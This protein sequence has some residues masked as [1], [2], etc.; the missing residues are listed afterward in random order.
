MNSLVYTLGALG[1]AQTWGRAAL[2]G[3]MRHLVPVLLGRADYVLPGTSTPLRQ[4]FTGVYWPVDFV[5]R[6][7][8][9][10]FYEAV[11][12]SHPATSAIGIYFL[13]QYLGCL[14]VMYTDSLRGSRPSVLRSVRFPPPP[15][16]MYG[17]AR[18]ADMSCV[19]RRRATMWSLLFQLT[20]IGCT[21]WVWALSFLSTSATVV[22]G[23]GGGGGEPRDRGKAGLLGASSV[24]DS[25]SIYLLPPAFLLGYVVPAVAMALP[26]P[27]MVSE[28][29]QQYAIAA[30]NMFPLLVLAA[31][32]A[33]G[34]AAKTT[35]AASRGFW[36]GASPAASHLRSVRV[37]NLL[38]LVATCACHWSVVGVSLASVLFPSVFAPGYARELGPGSLALPPVAITQGETFGDGVRSF[39]LW[40]QVFGYSLVGLVVL[41]QVH[42]AAG[43][44]GQATGPF[45][46]AL[47]TLALSV[48]AGPGSAILIMS[49]WRDEMVF[50]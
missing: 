46:L 43:A 21:G 19:T 40:D 26:S 45:R 50:A 27:G 48:V 39:M 16:C 41:A 35:A 29:F 7:L 28:A 3:S 30:W 31:H 17:S 13:G 4:A 33:V 14:V 1:T 20:A 12:G 25:L 18:G 6:V 49:W 38:T 23:G 22:V 36:G 10:F 34:A 11:D 5:L 24:R 47:V 32:H 15:V 2:D 9:V 44:C 8:V 37:V 42:R